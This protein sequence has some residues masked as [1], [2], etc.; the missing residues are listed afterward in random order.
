VVETVNVAVDA[1][2]AT[3][4]EAGTVALV[5][6]DD[7]LT[8]SPLEGAGPLRVT[9]PV[10]LL[11]PTTE[12]GEIAMLCSAEGVTASIVVFVTEPKTAVM[13]AVVVVATDEV[14]IVKVAVEPPA[15]T[16]TEVGTV[17]LVVL[18]DKLTLVAP[19][20]AGPV[21]VTVPV[22]VFP[23]TRVLGDTV[24]PDSCAAV[25]ASVADFV[26]LPC[27]PVILTVV[28]APTAEVPILNVT[29]VAPANTVT[30]AGTVALALL[31]E[32]LITVPPGP[33]A[34]LSVTVPIADVPPRTEV[35][36]TLMPASVAGVIVSVAVSV[37]LPSKAVIVAEV[38]ADTAVVEIVKVADVAPAKTVTEAGTVP[39]ALPEDRL[40]SVPFGPAG[41]LRVMVPVDGFPPVTEVGETER[42]LKVAGVIVSV[43]V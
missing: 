15:A 34:P 21:R 13:V 6:L 17:T 35:G 31:D 41:P 18:D 28:Y 3:V 40:T 9:V 4:T 14:V 37:T 10:E 36:E 1:P 11:P 24:R 33:A 23:P 42:A 43:A 2:A 30:L 27:E 39:L 29:D 25:I 5:L 22:E 16:F 12:V 19:G 20:P 7:R 32:R 26:V 8:L 38:L